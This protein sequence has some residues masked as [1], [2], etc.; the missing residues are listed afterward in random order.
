LADTDALLKILL[1]GLSGPIDNKTYPT[2]MP[3]MADNNDEW[4]AS[5]AN[6]IRFEFGTPVPFT[7]PAA[8]QA[9]AKP[10]GTAAGSATPAARPAAFRRSLPIIKPD[11][12][13][14]LRQQTAQRTTPYTLADLE[15]PGQ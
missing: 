4:I 3:S 9:G 8:N 1:R 5:V 7:P 12:V 10:A 2:L 13:A 6:Y 14:T 11:E 15:K